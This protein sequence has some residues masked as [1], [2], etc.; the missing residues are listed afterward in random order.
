MQ[1]TLL[2]ATGL[3]GQQVLRQALEAGHDVTV[4][5]RDPARLPQRDEPRV[6]VVT[7]DATNAD[8][9]KRA[10]HGSRAVISAL[11]PGRDLKSPF[12]VL[13][14]EAMLSA[15]ADNPGARVVWMSSLGAGDTA[16]LQ[17]VVQAA[18]ARLLLGDLMANKGMAD[19][20]ITASG[21]DATIVLPVK[22]TEGP[23]TR[24]YKTFDADHHVG[25]VGGRVSRADVADAMLKAATSAQQPGRRIIVAG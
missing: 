12:P 2:G 5:V 20:R 15:M 24:D 6:T 23:R 1:I 25:R 3:T 13:S 14:A 19:K 16:R 18:A 10:I 17:S 11:G 22:L 4:L 21:L 9:V 8:D 7:G